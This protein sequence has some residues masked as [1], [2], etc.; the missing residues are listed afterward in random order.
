MSRWRWLTIP[1]MWHKRWPWRGFCCWIGRHDY[2]MV[3]T[4]SANRV[5]LFCVYC[6]HRKVTMAG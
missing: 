2:E 6:E 1:S 4:I 3:C 5:L